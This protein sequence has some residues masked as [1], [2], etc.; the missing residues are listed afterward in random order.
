MP[1][2]HSPLSLQMDDSTQPS[3]VE[4]THVTIMLCQT[5]AVDAV[6]L[7]I[8]VGEM[9]ASLGQTAVEN[10]RWSKPSPESVIRWVARVHQYVFWGTGS[11][12]SC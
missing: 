8:G 5:V 7:T 3:L 11:T 10:P 6:S 4:F 2:G 1:P 12:I 9:L